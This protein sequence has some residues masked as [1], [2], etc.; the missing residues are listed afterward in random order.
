[1]KASKQTIV[2]TGGIASGKTFVS[3]Y[4]ASLSANVID[5]DVI[6]RQLLQVD[7]L[8]SSEFALK[9]VR[10][11]FGNDI[12]NNDEL[13]R[14]KLRDIVFNDPE[15]KQALESIMHPLILTVVKESLVSNLGLYN[16]VVVPLLHE[17]SPYLNIADQVLV[18]EVDVE[19]QLHRVMQR[20]NIDKDLAFKI[21]NSQISNQSRRKLASTIIINT[22]ESYTRNVLKQLDKKYSL[23]PFKEGVEK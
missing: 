10:E 17:K 23:A 6:A 18:I 9:S 1:M 2:V 14:K 7:V 16:L 13:D 19:V 20:D 21:I 22:N 4:L 5:T 15:A 8:P 12:F 3:D 11:Y